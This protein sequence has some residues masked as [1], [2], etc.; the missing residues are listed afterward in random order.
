MQEREEAGHVKRNSV[1]GKRE[2]DSVIGSYKYVRPDGLWQ[3]VTYRADKNGFV[4]SITV[5]RNEVNHDPPQILGGL[6][7]A[8]PILP[9]TESSSTSTTASSESY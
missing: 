1:T 9:S 6:V 4:P 8:I 5:T 2:L 3:I 7:P